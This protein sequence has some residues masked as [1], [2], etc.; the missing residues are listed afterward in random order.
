MLV[1]FVCYSDE[2]CTELG[3]IGVEFGRVSLHLYWILTEIVTNLGCIGMYFERILE[4][5]R[6]HWRETRAVLVSFG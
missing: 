6:L 5:I 2:F 1:A 3:C 4:G